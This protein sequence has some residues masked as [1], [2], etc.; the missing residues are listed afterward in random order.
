MQAMAGGLVFHL[1][2]REVPSS[3]SLSSG[4]MGR[5][6]R[7]ARAPPPALGPR[8]QG[9]DEPEID[10]SIEWSIWKKKLTNTTCPFSINQTWKNL[11]KSSTSKLKMGY[12][13]TQGISHMILWIK[14]H[15]D[16]QCQSQGKILDRR[17]S[18]MPKLKSWRTTFGDF[19]P[20]NPGRFW[21]KVQQRSLR[22][23]TKL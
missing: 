21:E 20:I 17:F 2:T 23:N 18:R 12:P 13:A 5:R 10:D 3:A 22:G 9:R 15:G 8:K 7:E 6:E 11:E 4:T 16:N 14:D 19:L 1:A